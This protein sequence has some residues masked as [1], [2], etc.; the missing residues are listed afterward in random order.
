[1]FTSC[2]YEIIDS[3]PGESIAP[4]LNLD[5]SIS[6]SNLTLTWEL[7]SSYPSDIIQP[8]SVLVTITRNGQN[9]GAETI[10]D[11]PK[12]FTYTTYDPQ[13]TYKFIV[14]VIGSV[15]TEDPNVSDLRYSSGVTLEL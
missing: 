14:K 6:G 11:A 1:M 15:N 9:A 5:Y 10:L 13:S 4:V 2:K 12:S 3:K 7:P 8:V